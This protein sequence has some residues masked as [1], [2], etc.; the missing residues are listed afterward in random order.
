MRE[1]Q[2]LHVDV[3]DF[4][5]AVAR[6]VDP[7]LRG[8][9]LVIAPPLV[10]AV[11]LCASSEARRE[12]IRPDMPLAEARRLCRGL[13]VLPPDPP[14]YARAGHALEERV[15]RFSPLVEPRPGGRIY[16]D[17]TGTGR[18]FGPPLDLADRLRRELLSCL[19]L[20]AAIGIAVNKLVSRVAADVTEPAGL[21]DVG[22][23]D[24]ATFLAPLAVSRLPGVGPTVAC[25]LRALNV[26][27]VRQL[28]LIEVEHLVLCFGRFG[29]VLHERALGI[30]PRPVQPPRSEPG[31]LREITL[32][33]DTNDPDRLR[34]VL[35]GLTSEI[36][37]E[38]R[39]RDAG[40]RSLQLELHYADSKRAGCRERLPEPTGLDGALWLA[41]EGMLA[42]RLRGR[43]VRV[44]RLSLSARELRQVG[45]RQL[46]LF[47]QPHEASREPALLRA[48]DRIRARH[49]PQAVR[50][51]MEH[52]AA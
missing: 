5:V 52:P 43:R 23:G 37:R 11:V 48:L 46:T 30:D 25:E 36:G 4:P 27:T 1:R 33:E 38:L 10:R 28:A 19:R 32:G 9:P 8:R 6:V 35:R 51:A 22:L 31:I 39:A 50:S 24:E 34:A 15:A 21:L 26:R 12:G 18:L 3:A 41:A 49:G 44:R 16:L 45:S 40:A 2:V 14:L 20:D 7:G 17:V 13:R 47:G 29:G 42:R